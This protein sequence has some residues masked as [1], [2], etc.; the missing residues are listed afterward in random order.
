MVSIDL[1]TTRKEL[2]AMKKRFTATAETAHRRSNKRSLAGM[3][4][5]HRA[6]RH[7]FETAA[8]D[9]RILIREIDGK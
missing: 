2:A 9:I 8:R 3:R 5:Y 6:L 1:A 7:A 4:D